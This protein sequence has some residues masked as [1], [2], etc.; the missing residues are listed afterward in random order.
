VF[1]PAVNVPLSVKLPA[2]LSVVGPVRVP[3]ISMCR[4]FVAEV[5]V[6]VVDPEAGIRRRCQGAGN[7]DV[8]ECRY[9]RS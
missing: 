6:M 4:K 1:E 5:P 8:I 7:S 3:L 2:T 9:A